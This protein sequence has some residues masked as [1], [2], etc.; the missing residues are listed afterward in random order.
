VKVVVLMTMPP[1]NGDTH[2]Q[3]L[4]D[5]LHACKYAFTARDVLGIV[6]SVCHAALENFPVVSEEGGKTLQLYLTFVRNMVAIPDADDCDRAA[7][8]FHLSTLS[9]RPLHDS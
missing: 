4:L 3:A 9:V 7:T 2:P 1:A 5:V 6:T 8:K